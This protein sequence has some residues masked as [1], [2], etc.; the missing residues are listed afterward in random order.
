MTTSGLLDGVT[1]LG[2]L[3]TVRGKFVA[4]LLPPVVVAVL[5][6]WAVLGVLRILADQPGGAAGF[7]SALRAGGVAGQI[8][9]DGLVLVILA[10]VLVGAS[11]HAYR[12]R[13]GQPLACLLEAI[14]DS[15]RCGD[16]IPVAWYSDDDMGTAIGAYNDMLAR[17]AMERVASRRGEERLALAL[18]ATRAGVWDLDLATRARWWSPEF[19]HMVGYDH[20]ELPMS[21]SSFKALVHPDD[22]AAVRSL[23]KRHLSGDLA[24]FRAQYRL[25]HRRGDWLWVEDVGRA[26]RDSHGTV[27]R[28]IGTIVDITERKRA[29]QELDQSRRLLHAVIDVIPAAISVKDADARHLLLNRYLAELSGVSADGAVAGAP[30]M[31]GDWVSEEDLARDRRVLA[32]GEALAFFEDSSVDRDGAIRH[33]MTTKIPLK[34]DRGASTHVVTVALD[35]TSHKS[36]EATVRKAG[37]QLH[38]VLN[39]SPVGVCIAG[40]DGQIRWSNARLAEQLG[41]PSEGLLG[42]QLADWLAARDDAERLADHL[43]HDLTMRDIEVQCRRDDG[44]LWWALVSSDPVEF[45]GT[46]EI[47]LW[48]YDITGRKQIEAALREREDRLTLALAATNAGIWDLDLKTGV[49]WWSPEFLRMTGRKPGDVPMTTVGWKSVVHPDDLPRVRE[50][51]KRHLRGED[52]EFRAQYRV[53]AP[54]GSWTW[55]E[56]IG[57]AIRDDAG[58][59]VRFVGTVVDVTQ[60]KQQEGVLARKSAV[61]ELTLES[62]DQGISMFDGDLKLIAFNRLFLEILGF[63][64]E[65]GALGRP[66]AD[67]VRINAERGEYGPGDPEPL[68]EER[69]A[70]ARQFRPHVFERFRPN[71]RVIEVRGQPVPG[72]GFVTTYSD[73]TEHKRAEE[74]LRLAKEQAEEATRAKSTFLATMSHEIRTPMNGVVAMAELLEQ[75]SLSRDQRGM[76]RVIRESAGALLAIINDLLDFSKIEVGRLELEMVELS[77]LDITE[78]VAELVAS[79]AAEKGLDLVVTV[80]PGVPDRRRGDPLRLRQILLNLVG[81]AIKF[82]RAGEVVISVEAIAAPGSEGRADGELVHFAVTDPGIGLSEPQQARLFQPFV[83]AETSTTRRFGGTGLGLSICRRLVGLMHGDIGVTSTP[84]VGSTFW[85]EIPL[86]VLP[87]EAAATA[88]G[89]D[90]SGIRV[91]AVGAGQAATAAIRRHLAV[92]GGQLAE[93]AN[94]AE[95]I[96]AMHRA[97][98][99]GTDY[100]A[101]LIE[102]TLPDM[103]G[104]TLG[105]RVSADPALAGTR[106]VLMAFLAQISTLS[107]ADRS[108]LFATLTK[109]VR[110]DRLWRT[111]AAAA[112]RATLEDHF[113]VGRKQIR[114]A[115]PTIEEAR[116]AGS[117]ILVAEDNPTNQMVIAKLLE[118]LGYACEVTVDGAEAWRRIEQAQYGLLLTDCHMPEMDGYELTRRIR[119]A[120]T[121]SERRLPI[122]ALTADA[123]SGTEQKCLAAGMNGYLS[124]PIDVARLD[125]MIRRWLPRAAAT[126]RPADADPRHGDAVAAAMPVG[127]TPDSRSP[128]GGAPGAPSQAAPLP[129]AASQGDGSLIAEPAAE[130]GEALSVLDLDTIRFAFDGISDE[131]KDML[132]HFLQTMPER[133]AEIQSALTAGEFARAREVAHSCKGACNSIGAYRLGQLCA[134]LETSLKRGE[135]TVAE[136]LCGGLEAGLDNIAA[137][138]ANL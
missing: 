129:G 17:L 63:P 78:G 51:A 14:D 100:H 11:L 106:L 70:L 68:I 127:V 1:M 47:I 113:Q 134:D 79:R 34:D 42:R 33:W 66:F 71:G 126:R 123:L 12:R 54:D 41:L 20:G 25:R 112:G 117:L 122:V 95:A 44:S 3:R 77:L 52:P 72:G 10:V 27:T 124:K 64:E 4:T 114:W 15:K 7:G 118:R 40:L 37:E 61:L 136:K 18:A 53:P 84:G 131:A 88:G 75:T 2:R 130:Q 119:D 26:L 89:R 8:L 87:A 94:G 60:R 48:A 110:R 59:P 81:N 137:I 128:A 31:L 39:S 98:G 92:F 46:P 138:I 91:L 125:A 36:A 56:D 76:A 111:I 58:T 93:A 67:F 21:T 135:P 32:S 24:E 38:T 99:A 96:A 6:I 90:L 28:F 115:P 29:E 80:Q 30:Q 103:S 69:V 102:A 23:A 120:E 85:F 83:Q 97:H 50:L 73:I 22:L 108:G 62:M 13:V 9:G 57:R 45:N 65:L 35:V 121:G 101:A 74:A 109:P 5:A 55:I 43:K 116:A 82:T 133:F 104:L 16:A 107:E 19:S 86:E 105:R 49:R 132:R